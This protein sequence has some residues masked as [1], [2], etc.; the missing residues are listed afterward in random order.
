M[1][2][3]NIGSLNIF[4]LARILNFGSIFSTPIYPT[5]WTQYI[6]RILD[7]IILLLFSATFAII[8]TLRGRF[9]DNI[10]AFC[11]N[12]RI[13]RTLFPIF[14]GLIPSWV[15]FVCFNHK[16]KIMFTCLINKLQLRLLQ[17][18]IQIMYTIYLV[19]I[20]CL[21]CYCTLKFC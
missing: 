8:P 14:H 20:A 9:E 13:Y 18:I 17:F 2:K 7:R 3:A 15:N 12:V 6:I 10:C 5:S 16:P 1:S 4:Q 21:V 19:S 11:W